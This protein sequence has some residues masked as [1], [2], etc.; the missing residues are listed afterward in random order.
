LFVEAISEQPDYRDLARI[1]IQREV[2]NGGQVADPDFAAHHG[3]PP[4]GSVALHVLGVPAILAVDPYVERARSLTDRIARICAQTGRGLVR[5]WP[6]IES[7]CSN[8]LLTGELPDEGVARDAS[9]VYVEFL[10]LIANVLG[11]DVTGT[12]AALAAIET[13]AGEDR[14]VAEREAAWRFAGL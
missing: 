9:L 8:Y 5:Y 7:V 2:R 14:R 1:A 4:H 3:I 6:E 11:R 12:M 10:V 13:G